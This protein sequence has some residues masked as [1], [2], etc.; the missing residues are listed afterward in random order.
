MNKESLTEKLLNVVEGRETPE[1]RRNW[2]DEEETKLE[3]L[4]NRGEYL[5]L[6]P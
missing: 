6:K 4:L 1:T 2:W 5:K 3:A